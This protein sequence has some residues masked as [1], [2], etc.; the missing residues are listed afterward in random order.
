MMK[1]R[2]MLCVMA[3]FTVVQFT[4]QPT[5]AVL[6]CPQVVQTL[7]P[8]ITFIT[9][10]APN[11]AAG[12]CPGITNLRNM[13]TTTPDKRFACNCVKNAAA[14]NPNIKDEQ[15]TALPGKC[16][17]KLPYTI[18]KTFDCNSIP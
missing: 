3:V 5:S 13:A 9:G 1:M 4:F 6:T 10:S 2:L 17:V 14:S 15:V 18:S 7:A 8:C 12:C 11:P 16:G